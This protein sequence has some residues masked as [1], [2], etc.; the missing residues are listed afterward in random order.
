MGESVG[1]CVPLSGG[2][3]DALLPAMGRMTPLGGGAAACTWGF[4]DGR[5]WGSGA[6]YSHHCAGGFLRLPPAEGGTC[7]FVWACLHP[8]VEGGKGEWGVWF[9]WACGG[10]GCNTLVCNA[11]G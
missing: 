6:Q 1:L 9:M 4:S 2:G 3:A 8:P 7:G 5:V 11:G 10:H